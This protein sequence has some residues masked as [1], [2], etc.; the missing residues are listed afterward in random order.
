MT[1]DLCMMTATEMLRLFR[2]RKLSP[3]EVTRAVLERID[4]HDRKVAAFRL[5]APEQAMKAAR[6]SEK[7]WK[8]G[9]PQGLLDGVPTTIKDQWLTRGWSTLRGSTLSPTRG[10]WD[11]DSPPVARLR[12]H[13]AVLL[14]K[15]TMPEFGWKGVT[16]CTLTGISRNPWNTDKTCGGSS[17]GA[18]IAAAAGFGALHL[19]SDGAGS[20]RMPAGFCGVFG[21][22]GTF[23]RVPS[24]PYA[25]L[26]MCSHVG[27]IARTVADGALMYNVMTEPDARDWLAPPYDAR[28]WRVGLEDGVRGLRI[29]YSRTLGYAKVD[30]ELGQ[31]VDK[32]VKVLADLGA[33]VEE[34]D[35]GFSDP[36]EPFYAHYAGAMMVNLEKLGPKAREELDPGFV[37][38]AED[39]KR[40]SAKDM[41]LAWDARHN[42]GRHMNVFHQTYDVLI[43]PQMSLVAFDAG[44]EFPA[45]RGMKSWFDWSPFCFP[46][47]F[48]QQ[49]A[50]TVPCG[51]TRD[52]LPAALQVVTA[53][54]R[55]DLAFRVARAYESACPFAMPGVSRL[56]KGGA[57]K[58]EKVR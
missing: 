12:E 3:V 23:G 36:F 20:I 25:T 33:I 24:H 11:E 16:D 22:K 51:L 57:K 19:G 2:V 10:K 38:M 26:P 49:P 4:R 52:G 39:G 28:D 31:L 17:G 40:Y 7:R 21:L 1:D 29:A 55:E 56:G 6:Q 42:L 53:R 50:A 32:A 14:G 58:R 5:V 44:R 30:R 27:P 15:T 54:Y 13:G 37:R 41:L 9:A 45:G 48:T 43:T 47:N 35:P 46:F 18:A 8:N 34:R